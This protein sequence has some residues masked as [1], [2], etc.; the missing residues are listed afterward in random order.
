MMTR[1]SESRSAFPHTVDM[2]APSISKEAVNVNGAPKGQLQ[3]TLGGRGTNGK[4]N[5]I[6][7]T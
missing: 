1:K 2:E 6:S 3:G 7:D 5:R 4:W